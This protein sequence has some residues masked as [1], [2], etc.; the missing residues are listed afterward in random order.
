MA[1]QENRSA[2]RHYHI[3][4]NKSMISGGCA[5]YIHDS[6]YSFRTHS[7][8]DSIHSVDLWCCK[9]SE[10]EPLQPF[11]ITAP[12]NW[13]IAHL[14]NLVWEKIQ[15]EKSIP[16]RQR[17]AFLAKDLVLRK[18]TEDVFLEPFDT[19][20]DRIVEAHT[21]SNFVKLPFI[22]TVSV[23]FPV[24]V[25]SGI[26]H[27]IAVVPPIAEETTRPTWRGTGD[28]LPAHGS[29]LPPNLGE[30][31]S[32]PACLTIHSLRRV[33]FIHST[34]GNGVWTLPE[35]EKQ[36]IHPSRFVEH[37]LVEKQHLRSFSTNTFWK[38]RLTQWWCIY[39]NGVVKMR[40]LSDGMFGCQT[41]AFSSSRVQ[42]S[43]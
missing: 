18:F 11:P 27:V 13:T 25:N 34:S 31:R 39:R 17:E 23:A 35:A 9:S 15:P 12:K 26:I 2:N 20:A 41:R 30:T 37:P 28:E 6:S 32:L 24:P 7:M 19:L 1:E 42:S 3:Y 33:R 8:T 43:S 40:Y 36:Q 29:P 5:A 38:L 16:P 14:K 21:L 10:N 4:S 22:A